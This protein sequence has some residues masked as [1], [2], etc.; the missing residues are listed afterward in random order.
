MLGYNR[1]A[2]R[3]S[4]RNLGLR[5][6]T[7]R[8]R[9][10]EPWRSQ[11]LKIDSP[12]QPS[13]LLKA[14]ATGGV[15][16]VFWK[17]TTSHSIFHRMA[18][19]RTM[20]LQSNIEEGLCLSFPCQFLVCGVLPYQMLHLHVPSSNNPTRNSNYTKILKISMERYERSLGTPES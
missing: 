18:S 15:L 10:T 16:L 6:L 5:P 2:Q 12:A 11:L 20:W 19:R 8:L 17:I 13:L 14:A 9:V 3:K 7:P 4:T 1:D